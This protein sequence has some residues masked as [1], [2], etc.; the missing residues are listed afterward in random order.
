MPQY[1]QTGCSRMSLSGL[2][3]L[4]SPGHEERVLGWLAG[5]EA[6]ADNFQCSCFVP[7]NLHYA[8]TDVTLP[9]NNKSMNI[10]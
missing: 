5:Q 10:F 2:S 7:D 1:C 6:G 4:P 9:H 3:Q 8:C